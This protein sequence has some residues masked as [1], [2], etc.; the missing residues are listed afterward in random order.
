MDERKMPWELHKSVATGRG[1][2]MNHRNTSA[3]I[4]LTGLAADPEDTQMPLSVELE[5]L[6]LV[7]GTDTKLTLDGTDQRWTLERRRKCK[8]IS[9]QQDKKLPEDQ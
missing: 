8:N 3:Y 7:D 2:E 6:A 4:V 9:T 1:H 5:Q